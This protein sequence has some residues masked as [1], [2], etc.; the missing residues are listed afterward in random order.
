MAEQPDIVVTD[1]GAPEDHVNVNVNGVDIFVHQEEAKQF[2][3]DVYADHN[4]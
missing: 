2:I 1:A 3:Q 4:K